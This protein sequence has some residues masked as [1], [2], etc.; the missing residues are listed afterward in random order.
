MSVMQLANLDDW[1]SP[2]QF[3]IS[4]FAPSRFHVHYIVNF[5]KEMHFTSSTLNGNSFQQVRWIGINVRAKSFSRERKGELLSFINMRWSKQ[6]RR[7]HKPKEATI[8]IKASVTH[9]PERH[10]TKEAKRQ[11]G[12]FLNR[13]E[14]WSE[15]KTGIL[16]GTASW[17]SP[18]GMGSLVAAFPIW[19]WDEP[20]K[21]HLWTTTN[22]TAEN[23]I[24][25]LSMK[26]RMPEK[27][28]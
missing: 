9:K 3:H 12:S 26:Q 21:S 13:D 14:R 5:I 24:R 22:L 25:R 1:G 23:L 4:V 15:G 20:G 18:D 19:K 10:S 27:L 17:K 16:V 7:S 8:K 2:F 28:G 6:W 11:P